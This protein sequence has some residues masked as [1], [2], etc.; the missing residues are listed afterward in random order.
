MVYFVLYAIAEII[1]P[2]WGVTPAD[3]SDKSTAAQIC[4]CS[5]DKWKY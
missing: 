1:L 3:K 2:D 4:V 5:G